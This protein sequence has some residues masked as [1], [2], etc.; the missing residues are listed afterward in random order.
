MRFLGGGANSRH[1]GRSKRKHLGKMLFGFDEE[2]HEDWSDLLTLDEGRKPK[3]IAGCPVE[4]HGRKGCYVADCEQIG[5]LKIGYNT[6][7]VTNVA[8]WD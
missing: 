8:H 4:S 7:D 2:V 1:K 6:N 5:G 3:A